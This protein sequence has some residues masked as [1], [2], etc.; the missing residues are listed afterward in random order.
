V[1]FAFDTSAASGSAIIQI[2]PRRE[3][4]AIFPSGIN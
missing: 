4:T 3:Q 2:S 1:N